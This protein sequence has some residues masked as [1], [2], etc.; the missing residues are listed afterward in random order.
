[1]RRTVLF[2]LL[3]STLWQSLALASDFRRVALLEDWA[4]VMAHWEGASHHHHDD[5]DWHEDDS[6]DARSH[7][8]LDDDMNVPALAQ[9]GL[10]LSQQTDQGLLP[11][12]ADPALIVHD[13]D[14]P[15]RPPRTPLDA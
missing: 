8:V 4:H 6:A 7:L 13:G 11:Q 14:G 9:D 15:R 10:A 1:M 5:G 12:R 2:L 3:L